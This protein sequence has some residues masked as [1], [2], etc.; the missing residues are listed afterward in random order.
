MIEIKDTVVTLDLFREKFCCDLGA[1]KGACC[2]EGDAGA[3]VKIE[4]VEQLEEAAEIVW[5]E[6]SPK[7]QAVIKE[8]GVIYTDREDQ[9][10]SLTDHRMMECILE[11]D[12]S[13]YEK[14]DIPLEEAKKPSVFY[15]F[16]HGAGML[17]R[18]LSILIAEVFKKYT[19]VS[20]AA[21]AAVILGVITLCFLIKKRRSKRKKG[22]E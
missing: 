14:A 22:T 4:E 13:G 1:C 19:A 3:P 11:I 10:K 16:F 2:I 5:D 7:A 20:V 9:I 12:H 21:S 15:S 8:Q 6:L 18:F 17:L